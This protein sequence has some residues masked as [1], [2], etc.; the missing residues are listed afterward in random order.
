MID[1]KA[2]TVRLRH[3]PKG[4]VYELRGDDVAVD[5]FRIDLVTRA[6]ETYGSLEHVKGRWRARKSENK[7]KTDVLQLVARAWNFVPLLK[8]S[9]AATQLAGGAVVVGRGQREE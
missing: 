9:Q 2:R 8:T 7:H 1:P 3:E 6:E 5:V 4:F